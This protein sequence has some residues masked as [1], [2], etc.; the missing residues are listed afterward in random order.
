MGLAGSGWLAGSRLW[1][2]TPDG[3]AEVRPGWWVSRH[4]DEVYVHAARAFAPLWRRVPDSGL[5][6]PPPPGDARAPAC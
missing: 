5:L 2:A 3:P 1:V 4:Q 6:S